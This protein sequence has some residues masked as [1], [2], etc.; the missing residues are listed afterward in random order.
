M[1]QIC[2]RCARLSLQSR[3]RSTTIS[4]LGNTR[5]FSTSRILF[6][7]DGDQKP[8]GGPPKKTTPGNSPNSGSN[9]IIRKSTGRP[10]PAGAAAARRPAP[11]PILRRTGAP[12]TQNTAGSAS[13]GGGPQSQPPPGQVLR[14]TGP[15][16]SNTSGYQSQSQG[17]RKG[18]PQGAGFGAGRAGTRNTQQ[19]QP[20]QGG[21]QGN[22]RNRTDRRIRRAEKREVTEAAEEDDDDLDIDAKVEEYIKSSIDAPV[23]PTEE[24]AHVPGQ[25]MSI[26]TLRADWPNTPLSG[27]GLTESV[28]QRIEWLA[29]RIPHGYQTPMQLAERYYKGYFTRFESEEEKEE[30]LA[31][32]AE[33][34]R[35]RADEVTER[36]SVEAELKDMSFED[37][38][39]RS[40]E[41]KALAETYVRGKY[42]EVE[43]QSMP[44]LDQVVRNLNNN[45]TYNDLQAEQF[46]QT[47]QKLVPTQGGRSQKG[48]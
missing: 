14:R 37:V 45:E 42:P 38:A 10:A 33:M 13:T 24:I 8:S 40:E 30:V 1:E 17:G 11:G 43:K 19:Q 46:M 41:R 48:A 27:T 15:P 23:N 25:E 18:P 9:V 16:R 39:S 12:R 36:K 28:Q 35:K 4:L 26:E 44:F 31:L 34:A 2:T 32:A 7:A 3:P 47:L 6:A 22:L 5:G 29:H 20:R 21:A